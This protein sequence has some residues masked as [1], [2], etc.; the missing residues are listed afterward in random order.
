MGPSAEIP[1]PDVLVHNQML[2]RELLY[3][4]ITTE[5]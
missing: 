5:Q 2:A 4:P 3:R 1:I